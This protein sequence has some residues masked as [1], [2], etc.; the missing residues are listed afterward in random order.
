M[1]KPDRDDQPVLQP[2]TYDG[3]QEYDQRLPNWWLITLYGSIA[4]A[5]LYWAYYFQ[6]GIGRPDREVLD[7][8]LAQLEAK[9][10]A[11]SS[12]LDDAT[13]WKL[14][15]NAA[16]V[17]E[18]KAAYQAACLACHGPNLDGIRGI[19]YRLN[20]RAWV[21]AKGPMDIYRVL[22]EGVVI[23]GIPTG[24]VSQKHLGNDKLVALTAFLLSTQEEGK[25]QVIPR[26]EEPSQR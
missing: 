5:F 12:A 11:A 24:M 10:L 2:H 8:E 1:A 19:G 9:R 26:A 13:L 14:S 22:N 3:I 20:D 21:H 18:G 23:G 17:A 16:K 15:R 4:F 6:L 7:A 25:W